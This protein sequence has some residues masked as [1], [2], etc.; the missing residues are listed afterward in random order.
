MIDGFNK[1]NISSDKT[2]YVSLSSL[3][4]KLKINLK[5]IKFLI[6]NFL[7]YLIVLLYIYFEVFRT[8]LI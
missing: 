3:V 8:I 5:L 4:F 6:I 1:N 2:L 7:I